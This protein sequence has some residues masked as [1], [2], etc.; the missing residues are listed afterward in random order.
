MFGFNSISASLEIICC[1][2][3]PVSSVYDTSMPVSSKYATSMSYQSKARSSTNCLYAATCSLSGSDA[4]S[5]TAVIAAP[6]AF[7]GSILPI[8]ASPA[9][10]NSRVTL[11]SSANSVSASCDMEA[12]FRYL[13]KL[14]IPLAPPTSPI[15][16]PT[17]SSCVGSSIALES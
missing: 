13:I 3:S 2:T 11:R 15:A 10:A 6:D 9:P 16:E 7:S 1:C 5:L 4:W 12:G 17:V 8:A 14:S